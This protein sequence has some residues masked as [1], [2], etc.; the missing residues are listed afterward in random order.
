MEAVSNTRALDFGCKIGV[1]QGSM[2]GP[3]L[4][5]SYINDMIKS[6]TMLK[7][8]HLSDDTTLYMDIN[9]STDHT[10]LI[11]SELVQVQT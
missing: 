7:S 5:I 9:P 8:I 2:Q 6:V 1:P 10:S 3:Y 4:F 11:N